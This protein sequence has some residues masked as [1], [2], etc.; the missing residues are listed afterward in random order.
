MNNVLNFYS[1]SK[2]DTL[3]LRIQR[4]Q[5]SIFSIHSIENFTVLVDYFNWQ[6]NSPT[7]SDSDY[8]LAELIENRWRQNTCLIPKRCYHVMFNNSL[9][10][11]RGY[12]LTHR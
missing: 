2:N 6:Y 8:C 3:P 10:N 1:R 4:K 11:S 12:S 7:L 5:L 9:K